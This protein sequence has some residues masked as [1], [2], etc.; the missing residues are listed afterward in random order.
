MVDAA[1][2]STNPY[3]CMTDKG[4]PEFVD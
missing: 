1:N 3:K 4:L 2:Q